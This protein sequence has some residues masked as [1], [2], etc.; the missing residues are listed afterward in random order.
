MKME[1]GICSNLPHDP[2]ISA[3]A[4]KLPLYAD[5]LVIPEVVAIGI[6][7]CLFCWAAQFAPNGDLSGFSN[8]TIANA[9]QWKHNPDEIVAAL[10]ESGWID[11][12]FHLHRMESDLAREA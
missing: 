7:V 5:D 8:R 11:L 10:R 1:I 6:L 12:Y 3:L 9:C 4:E 2:A